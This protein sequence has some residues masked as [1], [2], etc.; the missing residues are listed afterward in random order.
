MTFRSTQE[1]AKSNNVPYDSLRKAV[2]R[3]PDCHPSLIGRSWVW[4]PE[5]EVKIAHII[6]R[7]RE[8]TYEQSI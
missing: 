5:D 3:E 8:R 2:Q 6:H 1:V 7:L 4:F